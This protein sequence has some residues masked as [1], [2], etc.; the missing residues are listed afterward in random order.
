[1]T[2]ASH[3]DAAVRIPAWDRAGLERLLRYCARP[4]FALDRLEAIDDEH[5]RYHFFK[6]Q[7]D[8]T[9]ELRLTPLEL[10]NRIAALVPPHVHRH[11]YHGVLAPNSPLRAR[12]T[13]RCRNAHHHLCHRDTFSADDS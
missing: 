10:I 2:G 6:P 4:P 12:V 1:M 5:L 3:Y 11:R 7:A 9:T 8:G 13:L